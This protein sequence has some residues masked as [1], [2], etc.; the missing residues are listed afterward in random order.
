MQN[1]LPPCAVKIVTLA[2]YGTLVVKSL[3]RVSLALCE[4]K[5]GESLNEA[6]T[7]VLALTTLPA[8]VILGSPP[9]PVID[10]LGLQT[11]SRYISA[12]SY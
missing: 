5:S 1:P 3:T 2:L 7:V 9:A 10:K 8:Y 12:K 4:Q 6:L 11:L